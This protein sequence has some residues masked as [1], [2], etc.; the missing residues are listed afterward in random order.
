MEARLERPPGL[1]ADGARRA[2]EARGRGGGT[3][4]RRQ[5]LVVVV[6]EDL[7]AAR[8]VQNAERL[9]RRAAHGHLAALHARMDEVQTG[10]GCTIAVCDTLKSQSGGI[11]M[12]QM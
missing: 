7:E 5:E 12:C 10:T 2:V 1:L 3:A 6:R 9:A 11:A 4:V 8:R